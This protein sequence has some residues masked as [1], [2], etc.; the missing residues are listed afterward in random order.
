LQSVLG[1]IDVPKSRTLGDQALNS[2]VRRSR[3]ESSAQIGAKLLEI[4][5]TIVFAIVMIMIVLPLTTQSL[6]DSY[7]R[8]VE[9]SR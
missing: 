2:P 4:A 1:R 8:S 7:S 9:R 3:A 5:V 6:S